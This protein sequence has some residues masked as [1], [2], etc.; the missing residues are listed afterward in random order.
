M[1]IQCLAREG[2]ESH[3]ERVNVSAT[4]C[5]GRNVPTPDLASLQCR[6]CRWVFNW[7]RSFVPRLGGWEPGTDWP[8]YWT[9]APVL[10]LHGWW[11]LLRP[12]IQPRLPPSNVPATQSPAPRLPKKRQACWAAPNPMIGL[13]IRGSRVLTLRNTHPVTQSLS[14]ILPSARKLGSQVCCRL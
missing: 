12:M 14:K 7:I 2:N 5:V 11:L 13:R 3:L 9:A 10:F 6:Q 1:A 4:G 8:C